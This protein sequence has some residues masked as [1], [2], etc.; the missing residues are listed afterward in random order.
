MH[1]LPEIRFEVIRACGNFQ[2]LPTGRPSTLHW[3]PSLV[4]EVHWSRP[5]LAQGSPLTVTGLRA[6]AMALTFSQ[7][8]AQTLKTLPLQVLR[9]WLRA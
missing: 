6:T 4:A 8:V 3:Y 7:L 9:P 5:D 1:R 2:S